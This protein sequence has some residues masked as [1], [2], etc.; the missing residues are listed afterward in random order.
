MAPP[1]PYA[2]GRPTQRDKRKIAEG[3]LGELLKE[4]IRL[5]L[6]RDDVAT[7]MGVGQPAVARM[8]NN[9]PAVSFSRILG[10]APSIGASLTVQPSHVEPVVPRLRAI[11]AKVAAKVL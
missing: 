8:E 1:S 6:T 2:G 7:R 4:R 11:P 5:G 9:P 10:Y 3:L